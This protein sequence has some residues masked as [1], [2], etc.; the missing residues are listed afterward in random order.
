MKLN[1]SFK[2][3][4]T[5]LFSDKK[6]I[7]GLLSFALI[8]Y[9]FDLLKSDPLAKLIASFLLGYIC[10]IA[11][12]I[13]QNK[14]PVLANIFNKLWNIYW[15]GW[16]I[17]MVQFLYSIIIILPGYL[18]VKFLNDS[19]GVS[20]F[21]G[22][23]LLCLIFLPVIAFFLIS[24]FVLFSENLSFKQSFNL[25]KS[26][27]S[28]KYTWIEHSIT[29]IYSSIYIV[30]V[31]MVVSIINAII[32]CDQIADFLLYALLTFGFYFSSHFIAQSYKYALSQ[33]NPQESE[34]QNA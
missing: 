27:K 3:A 9:I 21:S 4:Y 24:S 1:F 28:F 22:I 8:Y 25:L 29:I 15:I 5:D 34:L 17:Q 6:Y 26:T 23:I 13:I 14:N 19:Y 2:K 32:N 10:V 18:I 30:F 16:K 33:M 20:I 7:W 31:I 11:N 12:N